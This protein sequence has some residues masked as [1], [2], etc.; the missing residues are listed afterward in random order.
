MEKETE[1][2]RVGIS[3]EDVMELRGIS[4]EEAEAW[5]GPHNEKLAEVMAGAAE[6]YIESHALSLP[7][8]ARNQHWVQLSGILNV[9]SPRASG[10]G[11]G[12]GGIPPSR[13]LPLSLRSVR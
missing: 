12:G 13:G 6:E 5:F 9:G 4:A 3:I 2:V 7:A 11:G 10:F 8:C 1:L